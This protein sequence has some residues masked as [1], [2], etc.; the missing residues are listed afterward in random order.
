MGSYGL[1]ELAVSLSDLHGKGIDKQA[2]HT[3]KSTSNPTSGLPK[4]SSMFDSVWH[5][6]ARFLTSSR[7]DLSFNR[8]PIS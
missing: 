2:H 4:P 7:L 6:R 3:S 8:K 1:D 5:K